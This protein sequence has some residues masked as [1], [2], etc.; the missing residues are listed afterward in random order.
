MR[1][2][3]LRIRMVQI[4]ASCFAGLAITSHLDASELTQSQWSDLL[5]A[6]L[7]SSICRE[8]WYF[9]R[10]FSISAQQCGWAVDSALGR[11]LSEYRGKMP[12]MFTSKEE[13][14]EWGATLANC[15]GTLLEQTLK[16]YKN[17]STRCSD[18]GSWS[19]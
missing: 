18:V 11:C 14:A 7:P 8:E 3:R 5:R 1:P 6:K 16:Q 19:K 9:R 12:A 15:A 13:S 4:C 17:S 10:C 2:K